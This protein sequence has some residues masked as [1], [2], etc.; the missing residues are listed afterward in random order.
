MLG[1]LSRRMV[2]RATRGILSGDFSKVGTPQLPFTQ[3]M[4][5]FVIYILLILFPIFRDA[6]LSFQWLSFFSVAIKTRLLDARK[7]GN[8]VIRCPTWASP[9]TRSPWCSWRSNKNHSGE[10]TGLQVDW[11]HSELIMALWHRSGDRFNLIGFLF[12]AKDF[13]FF[14]MAFIQLAFDLLQ[15]NQ[16]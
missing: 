2:P 3:I 8:Y 13:S 9:S 6:N 1:C 12:V 4:I 11:S 5:I 16:M 15:F 10:T 14:Q 7:A